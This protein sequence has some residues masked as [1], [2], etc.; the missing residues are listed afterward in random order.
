[1]T[2]KILNFGSLNIDYVYKVPHFVKPGE[3]LASQYFETFF[4]GKGANQS[5]ALARAGATV[6]HAGKIGPEGKRLKEQLQSDG[7]DVTHIIEGSTPNGH[8]CIQVDTKGQNAILIYPGSNGEVTKEEIET[9]LN[10]FGEGD[11]LLL[12]NEISC[13]DALIKLGNERG[14]KVCFNPAPMNPSVREYPIGLVNTLI[15]NETEA[16]A[17]SKKENME[18][19]IE[20]LIKLYP[21]TELIITLGKLGVVYRY[22][23]EKYEIPACSVNVV[24][25][26][27]AGDTFIGF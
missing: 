4:G 16:Q 23:T 14:L 13:V 11:F 19:A 21:Q 10:Q 3:T 2:N 25:T 8:A 27:G 12:Q 1:M 24:D 18:E 15:V 17:L 9:T 20:Q 6:S 22:Q 7:V 26:T 5:T